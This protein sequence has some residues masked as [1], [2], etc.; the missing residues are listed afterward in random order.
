MRRSVAVRQIIHEH[1]NSKLFNDYTPTRNGFFANSVVLFFHMPLLPFAFVV[2]C[3][4]SLQTEKIALFVKPFFAIEIRYLI[5]SFGLINSC[6][7]IPVKKAKQVLE[8]GNR[9][10]PANQQKIRLNCHFHD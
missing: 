1:K 10:K 2:F 6:F 7:S 4:S 5:L 8:M 3:N 9:K